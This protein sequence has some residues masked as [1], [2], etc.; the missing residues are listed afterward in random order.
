MTDGWMEPFCKRL[1]VGLQTYTCGLRPKATEPLEFQA[2]P[3]QIVARI[4]AVRSFHFHAEVHEIHNK[5]QELH[6]PIP[7]CKH[8]IGEVFQREEQLNGNI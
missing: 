4:K 5:R 6:C 8:H 3:A 1:W 2:R 7:T